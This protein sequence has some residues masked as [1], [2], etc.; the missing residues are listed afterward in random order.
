[1]VLSRSSL[2]LP[3][4]VLQARSLDYALAEA[5]GAGEVFVIGG[6]SVYA[7]AITH[8]ACQTLYLTEIDGA[9][10]CDTFFPPLPEG[11]RQ[12]SESA[13]VVEGEVRYRFVTYQRS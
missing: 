5:Q 9:F 11:F 12:T 7:Q 1:V 8:P 4:G 3:P 10:P 6:A 13:P 2:E